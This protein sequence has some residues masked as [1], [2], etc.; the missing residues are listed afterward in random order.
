MSLAVDPDGTVTETSPL[1]PGENNG[2]PGGVTMDGPATKTA[3]KADEAELNRV[4]APPVEDDLPERETWIGKLDF[5]LALVGFS[6][7]LGNVWRFPYLCYKNGGGAFLIPYF[8]FLLG[9]GIPTFFLEI[10]LGQFMSLGGLKAWNLCPLFSGIGMASMVIVSFLNMYYVMVMGWAL[11]Y[12]FAS[13]TSE[14][15]WAT[16]GNWWNTDRCIASDEEIKKAEN[17]TMNSTLL[18]VTMTTVA[19]NATNENATRIAASLEY[20]NNR[21]LQISGGLDQPGSMQWELILCLLLAWI[22]VYF[23]I[24]KGVK[25]TG[26]VVYFTALFPYVVLFIL[27]IR[28]VTLQGADIG[29]EFYLKPN[30]TRLGDPQVWMDAGTQVFFSYSIGLGSLIALGSYNKFNNNCHRDAIVFAFVNTGTSLL[31]GIVIFSVLGHMAMQQ[32]VSVGEVAES[33]PGLVFIV[34][35]KAVTLMPLSPLWAI[36]FFFMV[37]L[38]GLDS[39]FCGVEGFVTSCQDMYPHILRRGHNREIFIAVVCFVKFLIGLAFCTQ[40]GMYVF[41]LFDNYSASGMTLLW[42]TFFQAICI[43][44]FY[45]LGDRVGWNFGSTKFYWDIKSMVGFRPI[46]W[47]KICWMV[48]T[49]IMTMGIF[50]FSLVKYQRP[51]YNK[52]YTYPPWGEAIGW[53]MALASMVMIPIGFVYNILTTKGTFSERIHTLLTP[54]YTKRKEENGA[55]GEEANAIAMVD[56]PKTDHD[57]QGNML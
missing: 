47:I 7:G 24:F 43:G 14:L 38:L 37:L 35:P 54:I 51:T 48:V 32:G 52:T 9:A 17:S 30:I 29:L 15:P 11:H 6:V 3:S 40:G 5:I 31:S 8:I 19:P 2:S 25:S 39:E 20:W 53:L 57:K 12:F 41:Q 50:I 22:I 1:A 33:G 26:R 42:V 16:C 49:P 18:N 27:L 44:W 23:C 46:I 34:Y 56:G 28:G 13:F 55:V 21:V 10:A 4:A 36:L 45:G